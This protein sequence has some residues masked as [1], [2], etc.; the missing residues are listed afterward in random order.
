[1][2]IYFDQRLADNYRSKSQIARIL[3]ESW[4]L[5]NIYC[6]RCGHDKI[7]HFPNNSAVADFYCPSCNSE[8]ELK[9][10]KG[11]LGKKIPDGAYDTFLQRITSQN[12]PDFFIL[13]YNENA[14]CVENLWVV[15]KHFFVPSIVEKRKPLSS[16]SR[17]AGWTGCNIL[18]GEIPLQ[19]QI[20]MIKNQSPIEKNT[21]VMQ[22]E[23]STRLNAG[24]LN[25]RSWLFD[26]LNCINQIQ[27]P[28]FTLNDV[29]AFD[30]F[31]SQ[32][33][34]HNSHVRAKIRQQL[35]LLRDEGFLEFIGRGVYRKTDAATSPV[36]NLH[37]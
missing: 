22:M 1:M 4:A 25:S 32:R 9:S 21:V 15:P 14:M 3:T 19:G 13:T 26:V 8:F 20:S 30:E 35:Q 5:N 11:S 17:R 37:P 12:N 34:P 2:N 36:I 10:K 27:G 16:T 29:Y 7:L 28:V 18:F 31:L 33:H 6:P 23:Q 24:N